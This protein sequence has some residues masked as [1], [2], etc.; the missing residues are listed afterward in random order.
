[1]KRPVCATPRAQSIVVSGRLFVHRYL[2]ALNESSSDFTVT[3]VLMPLLSL[4]F[5]LLSLFFAASTRNASAT[6]RSA[7]A[8][9]QMFT[10]PHYTHAR[11]QPGTYSRAPPHS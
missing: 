8:P 10:T 3:L 9:S 5:A 1:M 11:N 7:T 6:D 2:I 4:A